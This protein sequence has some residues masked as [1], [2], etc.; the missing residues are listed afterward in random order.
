[1]LKQR[2]LTALL[3]APLALAGVFL[4]PLGLFIFFLDLV[5]VLAAW[6][7]AG[8]SGFSNVKQRLIYTSAMALA[9]VALH[10]GYEQLP[11]SIVLS[12]AVAAWLTTKLITS[13]S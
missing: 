13:V 6:E 7:W 4:L 3:L 5:I 8:L 11:V 12:V 9:V 10:V 1:M 2:L